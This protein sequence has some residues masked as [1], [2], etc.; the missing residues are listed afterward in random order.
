MST[1]MP[2]DRY[3][4]VGQINTRYWALGEKGTAVI[5]VHGLGASVEDWAPN[6]SAL[7]E[8]HRVYAID[9][10]G[11]GRTD[12]PAVEPSLSYGARFIRDFMGTLHIDRASLIG[13]SMGGAVSLEFAIRFPDYL[14][15][16]VL[17][18]GAGLGRE[19]HLMFRLSTVPLIGEWLTRPSRKGTAQLL[20][21]CVYEP[22]LV[23]D[24]WVER[25][26]QLSALPGA[27]KALLSMLRVGANF[28]GVRDHL[29]RHYLDNLAAI[30]APT[31]IVWGQQDRILP[32]EHAYVAEERI[33]NSR[34]HILDACGHLPQLEHPEEFNAVVQE[35]L[36]S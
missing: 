2:Q 23:T 10:V 14:Q 20:K 3:V 30:S 12:K 18:D 4:G 35:F 7:A 11:C 17:V 8:N 21:E 26:Y 22:A 16:L 24:E 6:V 34:L 25:S 13:N 32:V 29:V 19:L 1:A 36:A 27:Q 28:R 9:L 5:F 33:P 15:K 31:L